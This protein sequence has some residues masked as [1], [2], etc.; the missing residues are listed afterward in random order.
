MLMMRSN[1]NNPH[2]FDGGGGPDR[3][4]LLTTTMAIMISP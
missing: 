2:C 1:R 3:K 4:Y